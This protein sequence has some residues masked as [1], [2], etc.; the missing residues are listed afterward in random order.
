MPTLHLA[1]SDAVHDALVRRA[2]EVERSMETVALAILGESL[3]VDVSHVDG[4][5]RV[6]ELVMTCEM[7]PAQWEGRTNDGRRIYVRHRWDYLS[8]RLGPP[9]DDDVMSAVGGEEIVGLT[10]DLDADDSAE[11]KMKR[12]TRHAVE[13]ADG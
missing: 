3:G 9:G 8:V 12:L 1:I 11:A 10:V 7:S 4:R 13:W 2:A 6:V 5:P